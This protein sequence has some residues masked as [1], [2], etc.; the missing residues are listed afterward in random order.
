MYRKASFLPFLSFLFPPPS[1]FPHF[2]F[3]LSF[4]FSLN[5]F[6]LPSCFLRFLPSFTFLQKAQRLMYK[7]QERKEFRGKSLK[8][9]WEEV[10]IDGLFIPRNQKRLGP[11][12]CC[13]KTSFSSVKQKASSFP[14]SWKGSR[15]AE[16]KEVQAGQLLDV[17]GEELIWDH[18]GFQDRVPSRD[19]RP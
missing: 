7:L 11:S 1:N 9:K 16:E 19:E 13:R 6:S 3:I 2:V 10:I 12:V 4:S 8:I 17:T 15:R 5:L 14:E 18:E